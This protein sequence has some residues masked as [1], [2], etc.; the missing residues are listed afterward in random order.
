MIRVSFFGGLKPVS[1]FIPLIYLQRCHS[2]ASCCL[3]ILSYTPLDR[4]FLS[5]G[6]RNGDGTDQVSHEVTFEVPVVFF[7][8]VSFDNYSLP[9]PL[10]LF[11]L[12]VET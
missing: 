8:L 10:P 11:L 5:V 12:D 9:P 1:M 6:S 4:S 7:S 2:S 3:I